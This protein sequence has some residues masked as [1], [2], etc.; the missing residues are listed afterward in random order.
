MFESSIE[1]RQG[2]LQDVFVSICAVSACLG[3]CKLIALPVR[4]PQTKYFETMLTCL[5]PAIHLL[6]S[7]RSGQFEMDDVCGSGLSKDSVFGYILL[8]V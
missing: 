3:S 5:R 7:R 6:R 4:S 1:M 8:E 2:R